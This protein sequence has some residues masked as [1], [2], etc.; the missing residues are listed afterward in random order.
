MTG[1]PTFDPRFDPAF[2]RGYV[3]SVH[4]PR[5]PSAR[6]SPPEKT[7]DPPPS[8]SEVPPSAEPRV[9]E[10]VESAT[11]AVV[12]IN[13]GINPYIVALW[14]GGVVFV[15]GGAALIFVAN[16]RAFT[17]NSGGPAD[18]AGAQAFYVLGTTFGTPLVTVGLATIAGLVF[19]AAWHSWRRQADSA[20]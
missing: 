10:S 19:F 20:S 8:V 14:I 2:Q 11:V 9:D 16:L 15:L 18:A 17:A 1:Q 5:A 6:V 13:R 7:I 4:A 3:P 12:P